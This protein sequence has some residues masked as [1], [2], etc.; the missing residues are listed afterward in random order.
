MLVY[1]LAPFYFAACFLIQKHLTAWTTACCGDKNSKPLNIIVSVI[2]MLCALLPVFAFFWPV[3]PVRRMLS[4]AGYFWFAIF[5]YAAGACILL[6]IIALII[7]KVRKL[8][9][10]APVF[11]R[12]LKIVLGAVIIVLI[13]R[14]CIYGSIHARDIKTTCYDAHIFKKCETAKQLDIVLIS[15]I[16][17]S[18]SIGADETAN[19]VDAI[20]KADPDIVCITGDIY[21]NSFD[22]LADPDAIVNEFRKIKSRYGVYACYGN[23]DVDEPILAGFTFSGS[24]KHPVSDPRMDKLIEDSGI[25]LLRDEVTTAGKDTYIIGRRDEE[26]PGTA[27]GSR[28]TASELTEGL[29]MTRPVIFLDHEPTDL[30]NCEK[31]G[32]DM[33]LS[34]HT[35]N[36]QF[37]PLTLSVKYVWEHGIGEKKYGNMT[38]FVTSGAGYFGPAVR[39]GSDAEVVKITTTFE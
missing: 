2:F 3:S 15:D 33:V 37:A 10:K 22:D 1:I 39:I 26:K 30:E 29:D 28:M 18:S 27:D 8:P 36:G 7:R 21:S 19:M 5:M 25:V 31:A 13:T 6:F 17:L 12:G 34:G 32:A 24:K 20:N 38:S 11:P 35:H 4:T 16:H 23:H 9:M 14:T